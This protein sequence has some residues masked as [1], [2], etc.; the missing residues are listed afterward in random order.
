MGEEIAP[1]VEILEK[2]ESDTGVFVRIATDYGVKTQLNFGKPVTDEEI[3]RALRRFYEDNKPENQAV[4]SI[5][6]GDKVTW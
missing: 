3:E 6:R 5:K 4:V 1:K 2:Y